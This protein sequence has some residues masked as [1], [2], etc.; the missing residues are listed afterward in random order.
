MVSFFQQVIGFLQFVIDLFLNIFHSL[1]L[2]MSEV[3]KWLAFTLIL[4]DYMPPVL[5]AF[6]SLAVLL[7][8]LFLVL[9]RNT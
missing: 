2:L 1:L 6:G 9:G 8:I 7:S 3:P 4:C 5:L